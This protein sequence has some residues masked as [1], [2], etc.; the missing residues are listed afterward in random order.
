MYN[1]GNFFTANLIPVTLGNIVGG[2]L[3]VGGFYWYVFLRKSAA[4]AAQEKKAAN[5]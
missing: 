4:P 5:A 1:Y 2:A 3:F